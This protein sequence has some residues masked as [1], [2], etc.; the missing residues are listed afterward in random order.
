MEGVQGAWCVCVVRACACV[1]VRVCVFVCLL[2]RVWTRL[3][4]TKFGEAQPGGSAVQNPARLSSTKSVRARLSSTKSGKAQPARLSSTK[5]GEARARL[6]STKS[7]DSIGGKSIN[8]DQLDML[9]RK[10]S[11]IKHRDPRWFFPSTPTE[12]LPHLDLRL[13][14]HLKAAKLV[15]VALRAMRAKTSSSPQ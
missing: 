4:S 10:Q 8:N 1:C 9:G 6:G 15:R 5:S 13:P 2:F 3:S 12:H 11:Q 7:G 14:A